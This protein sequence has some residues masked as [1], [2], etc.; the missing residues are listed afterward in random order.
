MNK[1][2]SHSALRDVHL[3]R[4]KWKLGQG[5]ALLSLWSYADIRGMMHGISQTI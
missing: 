3:V 2:E 1:F 4:D 5:Q